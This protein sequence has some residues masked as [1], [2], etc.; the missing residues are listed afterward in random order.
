MLV[1]TNEHKIML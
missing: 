1:Y